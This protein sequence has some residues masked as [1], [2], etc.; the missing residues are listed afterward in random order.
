MFY[1]LAASEDLAN[2]YGRDKD[3][4]M[5]NLADAFQKVLCCRNTVFGPLNWGPRKQ[6]C[7]KSVV[8]LED[9]FALQTCERDGAAH[10]RRR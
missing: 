9:F 8:A 5:L 6:P 1:P 2:N 3:F 10:A 7:P 4:W